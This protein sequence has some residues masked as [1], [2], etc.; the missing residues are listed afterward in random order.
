MQENAATDATGVTLDPEFLLRAFGMVDF[1]VGCVLLDDH[2]RVVAVSAA[3]ER[4]LRANDDPGLGTPLRQW[5]LLSVDAAASLAQTLGTLSEDNPTESVITQAAEQHCSFCWTALRDPASEQ[6]GVRYL[7]TVQALHPDARDDTGRRRLQELMA[8]LFDSSPI[9]EAYVSV[10]GEF[11][12]VNKTL[13][14]M[15]GYNEGELRHLDFQTVTYPAD[16]SRDLMKVTD[17][18]AG[19]IRTYTM[20]K[21][22][23]RK[24]GDIFWANLSVS[25]L[26]DAQG[27]V[28]H[29]ISRLD[30]I[31]P[32]KNLEQRYEGEL[33][34]LQ[35]QL[36]LR[37]H[38]VSSLNARFERLALL[39]PVTGLLNAE[40]LTQELTRA[41]A[42]A[43][44]D[45]EHFAVIDI[46]LHGYAAVARMQGVDAGNA[47]LKKSGECLQ[48]MVRRSDIL[49]RNSGDNFV[50]A[51]EQRALLGAGV[52]EISG[53][54]RRALMATVEDA[55][56]AADIQ[57][58]LGVAELR[59]DDTLETLLARAREGSALSDD[60]TTN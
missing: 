26:R 27:Q 4:L 60:S 59:A 10:E 52:E 2:H 13:C 24:N 39:D 23:I 18:L 7:L 16:L 32:R 36:L 40:G 44:E 45:G 33:A 1:P 56:D 37:Q 14:A 22:Y 51:L 20:E 5:H 15:L 46:R 21:R 31:T 55:S 54:I 58:G 28:V 34:Q 8:D 48:H 38:E 6:D 17:M 43:S 49:G 53:R 41:Y 47:V 42:L 19:R 11:L 3:A 50:V 35:D 57:V 30:D 29:F 25:A 12:K 9:G